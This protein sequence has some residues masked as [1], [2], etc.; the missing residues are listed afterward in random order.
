WIREHQPQLYRK[1]DYF[2]LWADLVNFLLGAEPVTTNS[3]ASRTLLF[4]FSRQDWSEPL[5]S[6]SGLD[7]EKLARIVPAGKVVGK[8]APSLTEEL[9]LPGGLL[10][11]S[12]GHDQCL[13]ALG[14]GAIA[15]GK[16]VCGLGT[17]ECLAPVYS[18]LADPLKLL[19]EK[20]NMENHVVPG[21]VVSFLYHQAGLL[22]RWFRDTFASS[23][24]AS[25]DI[26]RRLNQEIPE[27]PTGLFVLPHFE[28]PQW[29]VYVKE[30][31]GVI[32]GLKTTT[33]RGEILKA[34]MEGTSFYFLKG[35]ASLKRLGIPV[36]ECLASGG[37][38]SSDAWLQIHADIF[39][40]PFTRP[41]V[42]EAGLA[43]CAML[44]G[45]ACGLYGSFSEAAALFIQE[46]KTFYPDARRHRI[47]QEKYEIFQKIYS[48]VK[49]LLTA[50]AEPKIR[51]SQ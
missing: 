21:L 27:Q 10:L 14:C 15:P 39:G 24:S 20:L 8:I 45:L 19:P 16:L 33:S 18:P 25:A 40:F 51:K 44:A 23:E 4:D 42:T 3:L 34:I 49:P 9:N 41:R 43:G 38:A 32:L 12:G 48:A 7:R 31:A 6:W 1:A 11:V 17:Y 30:T 47:Y 35:M 28:P 26:Y 37:G 29:P 36:K 13:N 22:V 50:M 46:E 2:L 5:L